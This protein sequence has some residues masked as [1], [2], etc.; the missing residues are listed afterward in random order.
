MII[1]SIQQ[2]ELDPNIISSD[3]F[4]DLAKANVLACSGLD[5]YY[6]VKLMAR[7]NYARPDQPITQIAYK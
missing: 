6:E 2:I 5:A 1:G 7:L 4:V 3:G